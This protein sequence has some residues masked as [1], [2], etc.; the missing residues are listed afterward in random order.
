MR[1][2]K[3]TSVL[4][5]LMALLVLVSCSKEERSNHTPGQPDQADVSLQLAKKVARNFA[6]DQAFLHHPDPKA[7]NR[8]DFRSS[9]GFDSEKEVKETTTIFGSDG[10]AAFYVIQMQPEGF[11]VVS[12]TRREVPILA[13]SETGYFNTNPQFIQSCGLYDWIEDHKARAVELRQSQKKSIPGEIEKQW[14]YA[15]PPE[16]EEIIISGGTVQEQKGPL[17][18]TTWGQGVGYNNLV[19]DGN[20]N[21][22]GYSN[23][24][25]PAGCVATATAQVM[26]YWAYPTNAYSWSSMPNGS[27][28]N[29]TSKLMRDIGN[30]VGMSYSCTGSG[31]QTGNAR[32]VLV[33]NYGYASTATYVGYNA[34]TVVSQLNYFSRPVILRGRTP[35]NSSGHAWVCDGYKRNKYISIHNPGT[36]Y[37][38]ETYTYSPTY[39]WMNWGWSG[40]SNA[41]YHYNDFTPGSSDYNRDR[42]MIINI[43]P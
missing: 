11:V 24:N 41:W 10:L 33:N 38:Y 18:A 16:D 29:E 23:G 26:R 28:S 37:E 20:L 2:L 36:R 25:A 3:T 9:R 8:A 17:M 12:A 15:A 6:H 30:Y 4:A 14:S 1:I 7:L 21:C 19:N 39:F 22:S 31:A 13:F 32:N 42:K 43:H 40:I 5:L 35:D 27:G 34:S